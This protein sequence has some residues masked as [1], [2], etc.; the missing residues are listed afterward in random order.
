[1]NGIWCELLIFMDGKD[2]TR[3]DIYAP[4]WF[5]GGNRRGWIR[6]SFMVKNWIFPKFSV[7]KTG[8]ILGLYVHEQKQKIFLAFKKNNLQMQTTVQKHLWI[9]L[10]NLVECG[11]KCRYVAS[12]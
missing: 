4:K 3:L 8:L 7:R 11:I 2:G 9:R 6:N 12:L 1:M 10:K 5:G